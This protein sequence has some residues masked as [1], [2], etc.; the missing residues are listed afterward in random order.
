MHI[1]FDEAPKERGGNGIT[2]QSAAQVA[3]KLCL[4]KLKPKFQSI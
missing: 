3:F 4:A 2:Y 1:F